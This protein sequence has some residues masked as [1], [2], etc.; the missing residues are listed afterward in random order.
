MWAVLLL[1]ALLVYPARASADDH[2]CRSAPALEPVQ[3]TDAMLTAADALASPLDRPRA[4]A[5]YLAVLARDPTDEE[6]AVGLARADAAGGCFAL[7][8]RGYREVLARSPSNVDARAGLADVFLW[9]RRW[10]EARQILDGGL[11]VAPLSP[12]LLSRRARV[13]SWS[14]DVT[15]ATYYL[16]EAERVSPLDPEVQASRD[17][18][19]VGQARLGQRAQI[20]PEGYDDVYTTDLAAMQRWRR[21]RFEAGATVVSRYGAARETRSGPLKTRILD[22]RPS[23]GTY[24]HYGG[25]GWFG[26]SVG[27]S[28][29]ALALPRYA[30][31]ASALVPLTR[32]FTLHGAAGFWRYE[33]QRDVVILSPALNLAVTDDVDVTAR[34]W[35]TSVIVRRE[36]APDSVDHVHSVG[37]R[38]T[39]RPDSRLSLGADYTY[40]V[41]L[42]R[43]P[44]AVELLELRSHIFTLLARRLLDRSFGVDLA[45]SL[46]RRTS[47][48]AGPD[49][50]GWAAEGGVFVRW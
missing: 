15:A 31:N 37:A 19:Y 36:G 23:F 48:G 35:L 5:L 32:L 50:V 3:T 42:E 40:G 25:G 8:E 17:R 21:L 46:E 29:P 39:W 13:A 30:L 10:E 26:A 7:A 44:S 47:L 4:R 6:A 33:D 49:V 45:L 34:Y 11:A 28:A 16:T 1:V 20:F 22:G 2:L 24:Y 12:E 38:V 41:Q 14:G 18:V 43:N 27:V 9:T